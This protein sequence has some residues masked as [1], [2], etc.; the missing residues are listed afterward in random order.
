MPLDNP[1]KNKE[2]NVDKIRKDAEKNKKRIIG[3]F[4][5]VEKHRHN[6]RVSDTIAPSQEQEKKNL[7]RHPLFNVEQNGKVKPENIKHIYLCCVFLKNRLNEG[8]VDRKDR[9]IV[10]SILKKLYSTNILRKVIT[11]MND[12]NTDQIP[13]MTVDV[14]KIP[15]LKNHVVFNRQELKILV[16]YYRELH[17]NKNKTNQENDT[18]QWLKH[19]IEVIRDTIEKQQTLKEDLTIIEMDEDVKVEIA[20][21]VDEEI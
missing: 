3:L 2:N 17:I 11:H 10:K 9:W 12:Q 18:M 19:L 14:N 8:K 15:P 5:R 21:S 6:R 16:K 13:I 7:D 20:N 1:K 4:K